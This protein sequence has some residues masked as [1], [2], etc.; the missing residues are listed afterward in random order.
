MFRPEQDMDIGTVGDIQHHTT[1]DSMR[2]TLAQISSFCQ[3][4]QLPYPQP[5]LE[6]WNFS[7]SQRELIN[8]TSYKAVFIVKNV[9][10]CWDK[11]SDFSY[12]GFSDS[13]G[14]TPLA[15]E[16]FHGGLGLFAKGRLKKPAYFA[17]ALLSRLGDRLAAQGDGYIITARGSDIQVLFYNYCHYSALYASGA[18][19]NL[20]SSNRYAPFV[21][22]RRHRFSLQLTGLADHRYLITKHRLNRSHGSVFDNWMDMGMLVPNSQ[23][24]YDYLR[25]IS[26]PMMQKL[27]VEITDGTYQLSTELEPFEICLFEFHSLGDSETSAE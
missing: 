21:D 3:S 23:V 2:N 14:E 20:S 26:Q 1:A 16:L 18:E 13:M 19:F 10:E 6:E 24:E 4:R 8:D 25:G 7:I 22:Q 15:T 9:L 27:L 17:F 11:S 12:W 5:E